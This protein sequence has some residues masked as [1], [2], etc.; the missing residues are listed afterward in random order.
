VG[1]VLAGA[2]QPSA[3][4]PIARP[5]SGHQPYDGF[6]DRAALIASTK[7]AGRDDARHCFGV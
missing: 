7:F 3:S 2:A 4:P 5:G 1:A 6:A